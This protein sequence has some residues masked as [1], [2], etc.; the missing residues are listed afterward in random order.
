MK[1]ILVATDYSKEARH[2]LLFAMGLAYRAKAE[3]ILF[4]A[5][6]QPLS[7]ANAYRL[8]EAISE[9]EQEKTKLLE[10][11]A[12]EVKVDLS[13]DFVLQFHAT[14]EAAVKEKGSVN[15]TKTGN[16]AIGTDLAAER[17]AVK[18]ICVC[19]FGLAEETILVAAEAYGADLV[20]M[21]M[22]GAGPVSQAV[23]G[24]TVAGII[25]AGKVP[26]LALPLQAVLKDRPTFVLAL[27]LTAVPDAAM[28]GRLRSW[29]KLFRADLKVLHL[30]RDNDPQ[31]EQQKAISALEVL[32][33]QMP[34]ISYEV[35]FQQRTDIVKGIREFVQAQQ[36]DVLALVPKHHTFLEILLQDTIT[37]C[38][39]EQ[40]AI[41]LLALPYAANE[42]GERIVYK[43]RK[44]RKD[45]LTED[46]C[47]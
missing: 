30:Y 5:F 19:K 27:D 31:Q 25:Q 37:G 3:I 35:Y 34:D 21:G 47:K 46:Q 44:R 42:P 24:S 28:L 14:R 43:A 6:N 10:E 15:L 33:K 9:L 40:A 1:K 23:L 45:P 11:Y 8:E 18:M 32:D 17:S 4:H 16:H 29:V 12:R 20:V 2:A 41:P 13:Q 38:L 7:V 39:T 36:A 26:V 22:R